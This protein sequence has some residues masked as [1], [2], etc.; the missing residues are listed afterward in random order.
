MITIDNVKEQ[1]IMPLL[2]ST[3]LTYNIVTDVGD[4]EKNVRSGNTVNN[5]I[6]GLLLLSES[7]VQKI[8]TLSAIAYT[9]NL[10]FL[11]PLEDEVDVNNEF[12]TVTAFRAALSKAF[13]V[14]NTISI[15]DES[16]VVYVGGISYS[17]PSVG[18]RAQRD[19]VGDSVV[20]SCSV[21][22]AFLPGARNSTSI[23]MIIDNEIIQFMAYNPSRTPA[24][25][26]DLLSNSTNGEATTYAEST[27]FKMEFTI[28]AL[29]DSN[30]SKNVSRWIYGKIPANRVFIVTVIELNAKGGIGEYMLDTK[31]MI[32]GGAAENIAGV[33]NVTYNVSL[34][35]YTFPEILGG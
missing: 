30:F 7:E 10:S 22:V 11:L 23:R 8:G 12:P 4:F 32:I 34:V 28:P 6:N 27:S 26:A 15:T 17:L 2:A 21:S 29:Q 18:Q 24:L 9:A 33:T 20:Y 3:G 35:P 19:L 16:G 31:P 14:S 1:Y 25:S 13:S 5:V